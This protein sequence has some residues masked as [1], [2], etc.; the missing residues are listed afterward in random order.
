MNLSL[1][2]IFRG[3][4]KT[5]REVVDDFYESSDFRSGKPATR[6]EKRS[7]LEAFCKTRWKFAGT[8]GDLPIASLAYGDIDTV[9][10]AK[11]DRPAACKALI[12]VLRALFRF[13]IKTGIATSDPTFGIV[14]PPL[15][16]S[17]IRCWSE[18]HIKIFESKYPI[19]TLERLIFTLALY[20]ALRREDL[21][22]LGP[23]H[24]HNGTICVCPEKTRTTTGVVLVFPIHPELRK[25]LALVPEGQTAFILTPWLHRPFCPNYL[26]TWFG[27]AVRA[28]GLPMGLS[29]HGLRK[30]ACRR[31]AEAGCTSSEIMAVTGH[32]TLSRVEIY[33]R[34]VSQE[35]LARIAIGNLTWAFPAAA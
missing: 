8:Y 6:T 5:I 16:N 13:A 26:T 10:V 18:D 22:L 23:Q 33:T 20:T 28:A 1:G 12:K 31:M 30:A 21:R 29:L 35:K 11:L 14:L 9:I 34:A 24:I 2:H 15:N 4:G 7:Q 17:G 3:P 32:R 25:V 19:G 27:R